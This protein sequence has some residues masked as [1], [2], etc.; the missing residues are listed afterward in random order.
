MIMFCELTYTY[1][2]L[3]IAEPSSKPLQSFAWIPTLVSNSTSGLI[4]INK[5][6]LIETTILNETSQVAWEPK[7]AL[8]VSIGNSISSFP[9]QRS[10]AATA[11]EPAPQHGI[12]EMRKRNS[13]VLNLQLPASRKGGS[14]TGVGP[15]DMPTGT[16]PPSIT[17]VLPG[18][19]NGGNATEAMMAGGITSAMAETV[20]RSSLTAVVNSGWIS[21]SAEQVDQSLEQDISVT[22]REAAIKGYS[23][24]AATN[25]FLVAPGPLKD[26]WSWMIRADK[27]SQRDGARIGKFDFSYQGIL[28]VLLGN[29][30]NDALLREISNDCCVC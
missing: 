13:K 5:E 8:V 4:S 21:A 24:D 1:I 18:G 23:M 3:R 12:S 6:S 19:L 28:P 29:G 16:L 14:D 9:S 10:L 11:P 25:V 7:G 22:M 27:I 17:V 2:S 15:T 26:F 30:G 20:R